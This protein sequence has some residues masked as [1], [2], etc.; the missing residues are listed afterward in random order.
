M[1]DDSSFQWSSVNFF[2]LKQAFSNHR[3][4]Q[5]KYKYLMQ[6]SKQSPNF[7]MAWKQEAAKIEG[8]DSQAWLHHRMIDDKHYFLA[9]S[10][11][12]IIQGFMCVILSLVQGQSTSVILE[13][14]LAQHLSELGLMSQ[15]SP[16]RTN[17]LMSMIQQIQRQVQDSE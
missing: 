12:R 10:E 8:C 2:E 1:I 3:S 4:W 5:E 6:L 14:D 15:L 16:S 13:L 7:D 17:G 11:A 9:H